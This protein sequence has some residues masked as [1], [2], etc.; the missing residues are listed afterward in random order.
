LCMQKRSLASSSRCFV[1]IRVVLGGSCSC[2]GPLPSS[3]CNLRTNRRD[4]EE[5]YLYTNT[6][7]VLRLRSS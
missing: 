2:V 3:V 4:Q 1:F 5:L 6:V 7:G